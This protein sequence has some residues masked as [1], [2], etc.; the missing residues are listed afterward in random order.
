MA[1]LGL[2]RPFPV[3][4]TVLTVALVP[5]CAVGPN[6]NRPQVPEPP[7]HRFLEGPAQ[8]ESI[9]DL[10]WWE[11]TKDSQLQA[12]IRDA[13]A[14]NLDLRTATARVT[15][16]RAQY[17]IAKSFL[18]PEV[19][20]SL[21]YGARQA[22]RNSEP[23]EGSSTTKTY[24][25]VNAGFTLSWE[26]DLFGRIRREKEAA[27]A[28][29]LATEEGRRGVLITLVADVASNY[30]LLRE[31]DLELEIA[32]RTLVSNDETVAYYQKRLQGGVSNRLEVDQAIA[33]RARTASAIPDIERQI[34]L[35]E[36]ALSVLL[37]RPPGP[38]ERGAALG[39][40]YLPPSP[41]AGI[42][43][44]LLERRPDVVAA[45]E[46]L[47]ASN[48]NVG[49]AKALFFPTISLTGLLGTLSA[50]FSSLLKADSNVW[51]VSPGLFQPIFQGGRI[52][53]NYEAARA[54]YEQALAQYRKAA[55]DGYREVADSLI[56]LQKLGVQRTELA[57]GV[58]ALRD[59]AKLSRQRYD[60]GLSSY[61]EVLLAD[62]YLFD[63]EILLAQTQGAELR[64]FVQLYRALGGG[65][66]EE[67]AP[68]PSGAK[69]AS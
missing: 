68:P 15:E 13:I 41:P 10:P 36:N 16:A 32:R 50:E 11:V 39:D 51:S 55:L 54:R 53:R 28:A 7:Q 65:W 40:Q 14:N 66:Q 57:R 56:T 5:A 63:Q 19:G 60:T 30:F 46:L 43:A 49:A 35:T 4:A 3:V 26:I 31:L 34:G 17:G 24:Q 18:F 25:N 52:K 20:A 37:G 8:A 29:Y 2:L 27:F 48:A 62:Q 64:A 61:L 58:E 9:A 23:P 47:V 42:P 67:G 22:S 69:P 12:L 33:N 6:Y 1:R 45:E 38:I 21:G 44:A 59:A